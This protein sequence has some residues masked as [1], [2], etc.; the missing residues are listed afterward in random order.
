MPNHITNKLH[1]VGD[2]EHI[3]KL[4]IAIKDDKVGLG[5]VD[6]NK[7]LPMPEHIFTGDLGTEERKKYSENNWYDWSVE[8]WGTKWNAYGFLGM[9]SEEKLPYASAEEHQ[10]AHGNILEFQTAWSGVSELMRKLSEIFPNVEIRY[11]WADEDIG[12]NVGM[13]TYKNGEIIESDI[14]ECQSK[15]AYELA[16]EV[17]DDEPHNMWYRY[18]EDE[19]TYVYDEEFCMELQ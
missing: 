13:E 19:G 12:S 14:P 2:D 18:D 11:G 3:K 16:F 4:I 15:E 5:S 9:T 8:N 1:L 10:K 6:F 7:I 17:F